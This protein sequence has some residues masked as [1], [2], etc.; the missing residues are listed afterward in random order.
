VLSWNCAGKN[1]EGNKDFKIEKG[2]DVVVVGLQ[3]MVK[4]GL[5]S[6]VKGKDKKR[7]D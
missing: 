4:L 6:V 3:E 2:N 1:P 5:K 7:A